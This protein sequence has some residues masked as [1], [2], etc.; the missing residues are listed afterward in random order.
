M[1]KTVQNKVTLSVTIG[2]SPLGATGNEV[3]EAAEKALKENLSLCPT[4]YSVKVEL[5][6]EEDEIIDTASKVEETPVVIADC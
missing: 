3:K 2:V 1:S 4:H 5:V 6:S